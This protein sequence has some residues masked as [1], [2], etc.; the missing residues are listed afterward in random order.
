MRLPPTAAAAARHSIDM[1]RL[2]VDAIPGASLEERDGAALVL[3]GIDTTGFNGV[4]LERGD[5]PAEVVDGLLDR[6]ASAA[7]LHSLHLPSGAAPALREIPRRRGM[8]F[9][10]EEPLMILEEDT[11]LRRAAEVPGLAVDRLAPGEG[12][13]HARVAATAF[14]APVAAFEAAATPAL[15]A[16]TEI[17]CYVGRVDGEAVTTA[18]GVTCRGATGIVSVATLAA[19]RGRGYGAAVTAR[20]A[21]EGFAAGAGWVWLTS[22]P[23][24]VPMYARL[25]FRAVDT[26]SIWGSE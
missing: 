25:G 5:V 18:V 22:A 19:H 23:K 24:A 3:T 10:D 12:A 9:D 21:L 15:L 26:I 14:E 6:A 11:A 2:Y 4:W 8:V 17:G 1:W 16:V 13:D 7:V 20:A